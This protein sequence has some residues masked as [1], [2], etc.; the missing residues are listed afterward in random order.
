MY[1]GAPRRVP[2]VVAVNGGIEWV[3]TPSQLAV[4]AVCVRPR[5][6][7]SFNAHEE[8]NLAYRELNDTAHWQYVSSPVRKYTYKSY[9]FSIQANIHVNEFIF[10]TQIVLGTF[11]WECPRSV[12]TDS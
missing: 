11:V 7:L 12:V 2:G 9:E 6:I 8:S 10:C 5:A 3:L 1:S 4:A